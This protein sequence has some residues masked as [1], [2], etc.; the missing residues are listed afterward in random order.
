MELK[1]VRLL[2]GQMRVEVKCL[3]VVQTSVAVSSPSTQVSVRS[4]CLVVTQQNIQWTRV[5]RKRIV[6]VRVECRISQNSYLPKHQ[7]LA[8]WFNKVVMVNHFRG[9]KTTGNALKHI[10][11]TYVNIM[12]LEY[13]TDD[14]TSLRSLSRLMNVHHDCN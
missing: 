12:P 11:T 8:K 7:P 14:S 13:I 5:R 1:N 9:K 6:A 2:Q 3:P 4:V 10:Q